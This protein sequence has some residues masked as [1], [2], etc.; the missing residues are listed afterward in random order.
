MLLV[1]V[2]APADSRARPPQRE[3]PRLRRSLT[4]PKRIVAV[5]DIHGDYDKFLAVL[6]L[7]QVIDGNAR[8]S[9]GATHL[10]QTGDVL[11]RGPDSKR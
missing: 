4:V 8:W 6:K 9:G 7:C 5:G 1:P 10:V 3:R 11:D 2:L